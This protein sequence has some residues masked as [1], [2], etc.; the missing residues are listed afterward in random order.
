[1]SHNSSLSPD[2]IWGAFSQFVDEYKLHALLP[3]TLEYLEAYNKIEI[4]W[5]TADVT[6]GIM[7]EDKNLVSEILK[8]LDISKTNNVSVKE[9]KSL[10]AGF[11]VKHQGLIYDGS[12]KSQLQLLKQNL[13]KS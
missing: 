8:K 12:I 7:D 11:I 9:D 6:L 13:I 3:R 1:M 5:N 4:S 2:K 10:I